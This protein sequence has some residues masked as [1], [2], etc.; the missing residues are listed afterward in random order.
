MVYIYIYICINDNFENFIGEFL[1]IPEVKYDMDFLCK[2]HPPLH[3]K[4]ICKP[5][6]NSQSTGFLLLEMHEVSLQASL[7]TVFT[8]C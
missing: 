7:H 1:L 6:I 4:D 8:H 5:N 3:E 2:I